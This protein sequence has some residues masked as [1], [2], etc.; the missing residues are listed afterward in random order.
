[1]VA[2]CILFHGRLKSRASKDRAGLRLSL[3]TLVALISG[4]R[5]HHC[6]VLTPTTRATTPPHSIPTPPHDQTLLGCGTF[7]HVCANG[8]AT[9][10]GLWLPSVQASRTLK[11]ESVKTRVRVCEAMPWPFWLTLVLETRV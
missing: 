2:T 9:V 10:D 6:T 4:I 7:L 11:Q 5:I 3:S 8:P 1:M